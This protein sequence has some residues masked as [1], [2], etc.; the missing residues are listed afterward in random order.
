MEKMHFEKDFTAFLY[1]ISLIFL[2]FS[3]FGL[4]R[5]V[6]SWDKIVFIG[7]NQS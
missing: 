6:R 2:I 7:L 1:E 4:D 3:V 5:D